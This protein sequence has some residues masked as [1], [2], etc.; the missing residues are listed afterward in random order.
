MVRVI[1]GKSA[2][3]ELNNAYEYIKGKS[4]PSAK[5][6]RDAILDTAQNLKDNPEIYPL[7][8]YRKNN[9]RS[10]RAFEKYNYRVAYQ[11]TE[12]EIRILRVRHISREPLKY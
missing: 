6:V 10:I 12:I 5:K 3:K 7:D 9:D 8:R 11:I 4:I 2:L 1:W